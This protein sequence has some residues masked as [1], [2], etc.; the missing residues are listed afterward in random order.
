[1]RQEGKEEKII[2]IKQSGLNELASIKMVH[3]AAFERRSEADLVEE[4]MKSPDFIPE[5]S[6]GAYVEDKQ[7]VGHILLS[8]VEFDRSKE[9]RALALA[10]VA[11]L[12][13]YQRK[14]I[15][16]ALINKG[17]DVADAE[18]YSAIIVLGDGSYYR[19]FGFK[20]AMEF[21]IHPPFEVE[22]E[23]YRVIPLSAYKKDIVGKVI[24]HQAFQS[25]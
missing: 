19:R 6:L 20:K 13:D 1:M 23:N 15:G 7:L 4:L 11:V 21:D 16:S 10:P 18:D 5:L 17:I 25:V 8:L 24:Y 3:E 12:P 14:G 9:K 2:E 22:G